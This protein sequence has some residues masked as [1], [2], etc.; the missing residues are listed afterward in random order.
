MP[1]LLESGHEIIS[2]TIGRGKSYWVVYKIIQSMIH[3]RPCCY[4]DPKGDTFAALLNFLA[5]TTQGEALWDAL[6]ERIRLVDPVAEGMHL[7]GFN[8]IE[9]LRQFPHADPD[10]M[11]LLAN[12]LVSHIRSQSGFEMGEANRLQNILSA[13]IGLLAEGGGGDLTLAELPL[14]FTQSYRTEG[15]KRVADVHNPFVRALLPKVAHHGTRSFW[16]DQWATWTPNARHEWVQ[17]T[18]GR[19]FQYLFDERLLMTTCTSK[20]ATLDLRQVVE[21]GYWLFVNLPYAFLSDTVTTLLGNLIITRLFYACMQ[22]APGSHPYRII[23][24]EARFFNSGPLD[25]ILET[26]RA[27]NLWLT[28]VVQSLDQLA[29]AKNGR[30]DEHLKETTINNVRYFSIFH[31]V[32]DG[33][34]FAR[35]MFPL[36]GRVIAGYNWKMGSFEYL[37]VPAEINAHE[38]RFMDLGYRQVV[39]WDKLSGAP[40]AIWIT[41]EVIMERADPAYLAAFEAQHLADTGALKTDIRSEIL[42]RQERIRAMFHAGQKPPRRMPRMTLGGHDEA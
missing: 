34:L 2:G 7:V 37:P 1:T 24:D 21:E 16:E 13:A 32:A 33:E 11:A 29:R 15:N 41:P 9:P 30:L 35:L 23:L 28:L 10:G 8:A 12:S 26:S 20:Q 39:L 31:N 3:G 22:R 25:V 42:E 38:R 6:A 18:E 4:V 19:I 36:T 14:L 5:T 27:Y 40:P 17:S